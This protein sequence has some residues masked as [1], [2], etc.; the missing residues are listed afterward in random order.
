MISSNKKGIWL[1]QV[2]AR[3]KKDFAWGLKFVMSLAGCWA[4]TVLL[5]QMT[6][7]MDLEGTLAMGVTGMVICAIHL[8]LN[9]IRQESWFYPGV[10]TGCLL[11]TLILRAEMLEGFRLMFNRLSLTY[12]SGTGW[13]MPM[14]SGGE[15]VPNPVVSVSVAAILLGCGAACLCCGTENHS[16]WIV[17]AILTGGLLSGM[18]LLRREMD[19]IGL[20]YLLT[21]SLLM[22]LNGAGK[23]SAGSGVMVLRWIACMIAGLALLA[24]VMTPGIQ[25]TCETLSRSI[26]NRIHRNS[27]ETEWNPLPEGDFT[28]YELR[29]RPRT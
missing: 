2:Q 21:V 16:G 11:L 22:I 14:L 24:V 26:H 25:R 1:C 6:G 20:A 12:T 17:S 8:L 3:Q 15:T 9:R 5:R 27:Y 7:I 10:L 23:D 29:E 19:G 13:V 28:D 4:I 18:I